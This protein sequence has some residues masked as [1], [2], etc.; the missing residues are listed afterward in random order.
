MWSPIVWDIVREPNTAPSDRRYRVRYGYYNPSSMA[1]S[2]PI[3]INNFFVPGAADRGQPEEFLPGLQTP[4][5][6][7]FAVTFSTALTP[8]LNWS[9]NNLELAPAAPGDTGQAPPTCGFRT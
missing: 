4:P 1:V 5:N 2:R 8:T 9:L 7:G 3:G 6:G